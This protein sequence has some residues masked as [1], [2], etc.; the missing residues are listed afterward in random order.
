[1]YFLSSEVLALEDYLHNE[2]EIYIT[3]NDVEKPRNAH[4]HEFI[5]MAYIVEGSGI[6]TINGREE[7]IKKGDLLLINAHISHAFASDEDN[8]LLIYNYIFQPLTVSRSLKDCRNFVDVAYHYLVYPFNTENDPKDYIRLSVP[9]S[10]EI[11]RVLLEMYS[12]YQRG[13][14]GCTQIIKAGLTKLLILMFRLYK[15]DNTQ[16]Q[17]APVYK[18]LVVQNAVEYLK[19]H[20]SYDVKCGQLAKIS[21]LSESYFSKVFKEITGMTI[22][23]ML[24]NI[25][26]NMACE[27]LETTEMPISEIAYK[28]GYSDKKYFYKLF[29]SKKSMTPGEYRGVYRVK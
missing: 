22:I 3:A 11:E 18:K 5:E 23:Q 27:L 7:H 25:R 21:Y 4:A 12:E 17:N 10:G 14:E 8:T 29:F 16:K 15:N 1:M 20:Y 6:H 9:A 24:Q 26:I 2:D 28:V 19:K 13:E